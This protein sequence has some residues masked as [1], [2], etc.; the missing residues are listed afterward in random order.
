MRSI[1]ALLRK[2]LLNE[3]RHREVLSLL[4]GLAI[5]VALILA[6]GING[7][8]ISPEAVRK[9]YPAL[10]WVVSVLICTISIGKSFEYEAAGQAI[11]GVLLRLDQVWQLFLAKVIS[12]YAVVAVGHFTAMLMLALF[13]DVP[14]TVFSVPMVVVA[15]LVL[16]G[17]AA[18][19]TLI[20]ALTVRSSL[21]SM[22]LPLLLLPLLFPLLFGAI[23]LSS[24]IMLGSSP[25]GVSHWLALVIGLD[26]LY[27]VC[28]LLLFEHA[29]RD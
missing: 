29:V 2:D 12:N 26:L 3:L 4:V 9:L 13:F 10:I 19:A 7:A 27:S 17:Y 11:D 5:L 16:W 23:E 14:L 15:L 18:L 28:G 6:I 21:R 8:F 24:V 20:S 1:L 22:L 25:Q